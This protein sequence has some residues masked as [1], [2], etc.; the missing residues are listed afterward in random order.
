MFKKMFNKFKFITILIIILFIGGCANQY[1][2]KNDNDKKV[3]IPK[4]LAYSVKVLETSKNLY[5]QSLTV[6]NELY[7]EGKINE[8]QVDEIKEVA[9]KYKSAQN[10]AQK[11]VGLWFDVYFSNKEK[12]VNINSI[13]SNVV[14]VAAMSPEIIEDI[15]N[16]TGTDIEVPPVLSLGTVLSELNEEKINLDSKEICSDC[17]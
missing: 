1:Y 15:N 13:L 17:Y 5:N 14:K 3:K 12:E 8:N 11:G 2:L 7:E 10:T 6:A 16:I 9:A 4:P